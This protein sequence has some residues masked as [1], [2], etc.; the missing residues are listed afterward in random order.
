MKEP[1][2]KA[3]PA[4]GGTAPRGGSRGGAVLI[5]ALVVDSVGNGLFLPLSLVF[6][7]E[8]TDVPLGLLGVLLS[9]ANLI[10]L[11]VPVWAGQLTDRLG[12]VPVVVASQLLQAAGYCA[13]SLVSEPVGIFVS[14]SLVAIGV[15]FFW[16]AIF[17]L[18]ADYVD[19]QPA[20]GRDRGQGRG[21]DAWYAWAA[22]SRTAGIGVGGLVSG[23]A[24][25]FG[26]DTL[27]RTLAYAAGGCF[28]AAGLAIAALVR[29]PRHRDA[30]EPARDAGYRTLLRDRPFLGLIGVN[31]VHA[32]ST[33]M[34][35]LAMP[36]FVLDG[37]DGPT[38]LTP[39][40]LVGST[41][42]ISVLTAP[43]VARLTHLRRTRSIMLAAA[44][45]S[46]WALVLATLGPGRPGLVVP[47]LIGA[48]LLFT[49]AEVIHAPISMALAASVAPTHIRGR[50]LA[51]FQYSF[52][53]G[54]IIAPAFFTSLFELHRSLPWLALGAA[55]VASI[56][57]MFL[58][59]RRLP[60]ASLRDR[61]PT[62]APETTQPA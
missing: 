2:P 28:L 1:G 16:C 59:E 15:R 60:A 31:T 48:T 34:L 61:P 23:A 27:F 52:A 39:A 56:A 12:A 30:S 19:G 24:V 7:T 14:A 47:V 42:L 25:S 51:T 9:V 4:G 46:T 45:W 38:W 58:L 6:F 26:G 57:A 36:T 50:Y 5:G 20:Q 35:P 55:N 32:T 37:L 41:V 29:A 8:L 22:T 62:A 54:G 18:I 44:L 11:P 21:K 17:T 53:I 43:V 49:L 40:L 13:Y 10:T 3:G 33:M